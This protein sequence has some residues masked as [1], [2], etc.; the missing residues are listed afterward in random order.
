MALAAEPSAKNAGFLLPFKIVGKIRKKWTG[1]SGVEV[2][3][4]KAMKDLLL[5]VFVVFKTWNLEISRYFEDYS[6]GVC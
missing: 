5:Y 6:K 2:I 1:R 4:E 3:V